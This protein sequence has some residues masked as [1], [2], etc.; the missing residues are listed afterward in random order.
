[1]TGRRPQRSDSQPA[2]YWAR[3]R[4]MTPDAK[5][6]PTSSADPPRARTKSGRMGR[7]KRMPTSVSGFPL[8]SVQRVRRSRA[9]RRTRQPL[10]DQDELGL[11]DLDRIGLDQVG[12]DPG[13]V[14]ID[15]R[16]AVPEVEL[17]AVPGAVEDLALPLVFVA[18]WRRRGQQ[19]G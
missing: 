2:G 11:H 16:A 8:S 10:P 15:H 1:M 17:P 12:A 13:S 7:K 6:V 14:G 18:A 19:P 4:A 5:I 9:G 3:A